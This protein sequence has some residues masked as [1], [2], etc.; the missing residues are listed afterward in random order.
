MIRV[1]NGNHFV[2][3]LARTNLGLIKVLL[4]GFG[5][6][7]LV[8][9]P[10]WPF[11]F[12]TD[13]NTI[14]RASAEGVD[15]NNVIY[16]QLPQT[17][18]LFPR[19][20]ESNQATFQ[21]SGI[22]SDANVDEIVAR[23]FAG[24]SG[25]TA[26]GSCAGDD[27]A[28]TVVRQPLSFNQQ[29]EA[30]FSLSVSLEARLTNYQLEICL[31]SGGSE[32]LERT[33][34]DLVAGDIF[35]IQG[36]S[37]A[38]A[39]RRANSSSASD[40]E[41]PFIRSFGRRVT[42]FDAIDENGNGQSDDLD[43]IQGDLEWHQADGDASQA[44]GAVGQWGIRLGRRLVDEYGIPVAFLN[45]AVSGTTIGQHQRDDTS[46]ERLD[47]FRDGGIYGRLLWRARQAGVADAARALIWYQ[48]ESD[49]GDA[50]GHLAG[51]KA[52][53]ADWAVDYPNL[54]QIYVHQIRHTGT[55]CSGHDPAVREVQ[56]RLADDPDL[57]K[58]RLM[59]TTAVSPQIEG[60]HFP[61]LDGYEKIGDNIFRL[62]AHDL[63]GATDLTNVE[64]PNVDF[65]YFTNESRNE[66]ALV[67][68]NQADNLVWNNGTEQD[69]AFS[70][71]GVSATAGRIEQNAEGQD[72][73]VLTLN[74]E[75]VTGETIDYLGHPG[76][77]P[78]DEDTRA[79][80]WVTNGNGVGLLAFSDIPIAI[81]IPI[82]QLRTVPESTTV[83]RGVPLNFELTASDADGVAQ[84]T[85]LLGNDPFF[86]QAYSSGLLSITEMIEW[87]PTA[88]G[89]IS[90]IAEARDHRN[91]RQRQTLL[92]L[93]V[94]NRSP[95]VSI[96]APVSGSAVSLDAGSL[97]IE[98]T[99][100]D[101][102]GAIVQVEL[103]VNG[104]V[105]E[106]MNVDG[107]SAPW[108]FSWG[109]SNAG[110]YELQVRATDSDNA[111]AD[112][113]PLAVAVIASTP[114]PTATLTPTP[115]E[116][117]VPTNTPVPTATSAPALTPNPTA[118]SVT[119]E[120]GSIYVPIIVGESKSP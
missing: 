96:T 73:L 81:D 91:A 76:V 27:N 82:T 98:A 31:R 70:N 21:L 50:A 10:L 19:N 8:G 41:G 119:P 106:T 97:D 25:A 84:L 99:G 66:V 62:I 69:F 80:Q 115:T 6:S 65:G 110:Q 113:A 37:N 102:D 23:V 93:M 3:S 45:N 75:I 107:V 15:V 78:P 60:C 47:G 43:A 33:V 5:V 83:M 28:Q 108:R 56:R 29:G 26:A 61:Y 64:P 112:S 52:L 14:R 59:S 40:N 100:S 38:N 34:E 88:L 22:V 86:T 101:A 54:E 90:I 18:Q 72:Q 30:A 74:Q 36:Q 2:S 111:V 79:G 51:F 63:Y 105:V 92:E 114:T 87:T 58:V 20:L 49:T 109:F 1:S 13:P 94:T 103:L 120:D 118:T 53:Y 85:L 12:E 11:L 17:F 95:E 55:F 9:L 46:P 117:P 24:E 67:M 4:I 32:T 77:N 89:P 7:C 42:S 116:T 57:P 71:D 68:R 16:E 104:T 48:G 39:F 35:L 44:S